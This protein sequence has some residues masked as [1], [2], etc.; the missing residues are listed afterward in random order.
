MIETLLGFDNFTHTL[1]GKES[2]KIISISAA[3]LSR[4]F[5]SKRSY[6]IIK[7]KPGLMP[8]SRI[9]RTVLEGGESIQQF[10]INQQTYIGE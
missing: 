6:N 1:Y 2:K 10:T 3:D 4:S 9:N 7:S 8:A 5:V